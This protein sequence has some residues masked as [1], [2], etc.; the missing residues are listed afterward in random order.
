M[1]EDKAMQHGLSKGQCLCGH[2]KIEVSGSPAFSVLC[3][4]QDCQRISGGGHLPQAAFDRSCVEMIGKPKVFRWKSDAGN[5]LQLSYCPDCG[6]PVH[7][8]TSKMPST[9]F[10]SVGLLNNQALFQSPHLAFVE[11]CQDWDA[12]G[13]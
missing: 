3:F 1:P 4:C 7:K 12:R 13:R 6:S 8:V 11:G 9:V 2:I 10:V 5:D